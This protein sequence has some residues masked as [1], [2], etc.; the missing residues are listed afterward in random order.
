[1]ETFIKSILGTCFIFYFFAV[2]FAPVGIV[3]LILTH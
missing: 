1:M 3:W 2:V